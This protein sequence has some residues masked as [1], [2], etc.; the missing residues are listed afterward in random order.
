MEHLPSDSEVSDISDDD[1][2]EDEMEYENCSGSESD[3]E[4]EGNLKSYIM[5]NLFL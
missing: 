1:C 2:L 3:S 4:N 5:K